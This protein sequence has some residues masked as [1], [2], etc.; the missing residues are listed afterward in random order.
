MRQFS[1]TAAMTKE[2]SPTGLTSRLSPK[3]EAICQVMIR[4]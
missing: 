3:R 1:Y 4:S 2:Y